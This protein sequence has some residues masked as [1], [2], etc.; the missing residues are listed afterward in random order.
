I[1]SV[2]FP[3]LDQVAE[4]I[5]ALPDGRVV[6]VEGFSDSDGNA[7]YNLN[8]SWRRA[9]SVVEYLVERGV[10][11]ARLRYEGFGSESPVAPNDMKEGRAL[12][13]RVEF[14]IFDP[15]DERS[16]RRSRRRNR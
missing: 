7:G 1:R 3:L 10:P 11:R 6:R 15:A 8:L 2:S 5:S 13:R 4:V 16:D 12:N 9:R 14:T